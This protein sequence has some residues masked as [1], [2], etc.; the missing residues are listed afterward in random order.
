MEFSAAIPILRIFSVEKA[1]EFYLDFLGFTLDWEHR[2]SEDLPLYMQITRS[3]LTLHLS[4]HHGDSTPGSA[5][6]IPTQDIDVLHAE[7]SARQYR[8]ARPG[9][10]TVDWGKE[11][12]IADPFGNRL[13]FCQQIGNA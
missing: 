8:Y 2:F 13:R 9:V 1:R 12:N 11:L 4:E 6:F 5:L 7:L 3:G 10:E